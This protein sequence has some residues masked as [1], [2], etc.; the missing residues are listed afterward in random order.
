[1]SDPVYRCQS[2]WEGVHCDGDGVRRLV[3]NN[4]PFS[5]AGMQMKLQA[6]E[7]Y[8]CDECWPRALPYL[9]HHL[10]HPKETV[11]KALAEAGMDKLE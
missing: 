8:I 2:K 10:G 11:D 1:M 9:L 5:L 4:H 7:F 6:N 3:V